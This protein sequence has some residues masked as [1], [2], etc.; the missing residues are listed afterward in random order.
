MVSALALGL[1]LGQLASLSPPGYRGTLAVGDRSEVRVRSNV[2]GPAALDLETIPNAVVDLTGRR[3]SYTIGYG[4]RLALTDVNLDSSTFVI[5]NNGRFSASYWTKRTRWT[6]TLT[7]SIGRQNI[8]GLGV[9]IPLTGVVTPEGLAQGAQMGNAPAPGP[10]Q[11]GAPPP[12]PQQANVSVYLPPSY[13]LYFGSF[14]GSLSVSQTFSRR[15]VGSLSG[16]YQMAGGLDFDPFSQL[17][18]PPSRGGGGDAQATY[19]ISRRDALISRLYGEYMY[20]LPITNEFGTGANRFVTGTFTES[21]RHAFSARTT[22]TLGAGV[23]LVVRDF[24]YQRALSGAVVGAGEASIVHANP[25]HERGELTFRAAVNVGQAYNPF[26]ANVLWLGAGT[27]SAVWARDPVSVGVS[28]SAGTS[29]PP[30]ESDAARVAT[31]AVTFGYLLAKPVVLQT[32]VRTYAQLLPSTVDATYPPQ[33][34]AFV[35]LLL[36]APPAK[37]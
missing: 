31:A 20:V 14:R 2:S 9:T 6:L 1:V 3:S 7:G 16:F 30:R 29:L 26:L 22:G 32:G 24:F 19:A 27:L 8:A 28:G 34:V 17:A 25:L 11:T 12:Q 15:W 5:M 23:S 37:F 18:Y 4:P 21:I 33:W 10:T 35:A 36:T 13:P